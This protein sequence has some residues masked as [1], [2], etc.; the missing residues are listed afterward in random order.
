MKAQK[1]IKS[2]VTLVNNILLLIERNSL[3]NV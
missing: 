2:G 1:H 3:K